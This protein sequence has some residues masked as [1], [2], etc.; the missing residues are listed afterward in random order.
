[1]KLKH[2]IPALLL[3]SSLMSFSQKK[4][5]YKTVYFED[6]TPYYGIDRPVYRVFVLGCDIKKTEYL[7]EKYWTE[8]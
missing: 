7:K 6:K 4:I 2:F 3:L 5:K 8:K 1:M